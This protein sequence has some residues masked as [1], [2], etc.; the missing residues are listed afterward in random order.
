MAMPR[1]PDLMNKMIFQGHLAT[2]AIH[3]ANF[4]E[5]LPVPSQE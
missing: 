3:I 4:P 5:F 2:S 1:L